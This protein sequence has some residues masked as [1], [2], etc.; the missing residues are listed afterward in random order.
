MSDEQARRAAEQW[1]N[2]ELRSRLALEKV[3]ATA[4]AQ[5][6]DEQLESPLIAG[7][8]EVVATLVKKGYGTSRAD[9]VQGV[10]QRE[11]TDARL[12]EAIAQTLDNISRLDD[13]T[14]AQVTAEVAARL[15]RNRPPVPG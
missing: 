10:E 4:I 9:V 7:C 5:A 2:G 12:F 6:L 14:V 8:I 13:I 1:F 11:R 3:I 15:I